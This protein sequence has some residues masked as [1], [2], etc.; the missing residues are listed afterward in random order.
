MG[1]SAS[2]EINLENVFV[3]ELTSNFESNRS[4]NCGISGSGTNE[5]IIGPSNG[6]NI[7][8]KDN[9]LINEYQSFCDIEMAFKTAAESDLANKIDNT[10]ANEIIQ[11]GL[12]IMQS[13]EMSTNV[14]NKIQNMIT[15]NSFSS[16][17]VRCTNE[18][19]FANRIETEACEN[20][21]I[22]IEDQVLKNL[23]KIDCLMDSSFAAK[24]QTTIDNEANNDI[25]N[26]I[27]QVG[28]FGSGSCLI[29]LLIIIVVVFGGGF[30]SKSIKRNNANK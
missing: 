3:N 30:L 29:V 4:T 10:V 7:S 22:T 6:C 11:E 27:E 17:Y 13:S 5:I 9:K 15:N 26:K 19:D 2:S 25:S 8:V 16:E 24:A 18:H 12:G 21:E 28:L 20:S 14:K 1:Q 23:G